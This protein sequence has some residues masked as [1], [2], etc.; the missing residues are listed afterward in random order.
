MSWITL[1]RSRCS[2]SFR[3]KVA[4]I[5]AALFCF[6]LLMLSLFSSCAHVGVC[7]DCGVALTVR[8]DADLGVAFDM[9]FFA[10]DLDFNI[11]FDFTCNMEF[12]IDSFAN[13]FGNWVNVG[14]FDDSVGRLSSRAKL[15]K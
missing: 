12:D 14:G 2:L 5:S 4:S 10:F 3:R 6:V 11:D 9:D 8:H 15:W 7:L 13:T 1:E